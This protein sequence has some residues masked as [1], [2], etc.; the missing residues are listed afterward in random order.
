MKFRIK[1]WHKDA[2]DG[3]SRRTE[4]IELPDITNIY[5]A[6]SRANEIMDTLAQ[7]SEN[8]DVEERTIMPKFWDTSIKASAPEDWGI[9]KV[10]E[11]KKK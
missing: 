8:S 10:I 7:G 2:I 11:V 6:E 9:Y 3:R 5:D 4:T 1:W